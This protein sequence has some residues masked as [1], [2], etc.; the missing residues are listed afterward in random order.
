MKTGAQKCVIH[1]VKKIAS[2]P[3]GGLVR[4]TQGNLYGTTSGGGANPYG[5]VFKLTP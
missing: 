3:N 2:V 5:T 1:R 4:D